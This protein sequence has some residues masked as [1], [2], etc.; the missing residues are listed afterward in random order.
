MTI[1]IKKLE[2]YLKNNKNVLFCGRHGVG[3]TAVITELFNKQ[4]GDRWAYFSASTM[5]PWVDFIGVPKPYK[6]KDGEEVLRLIKP[7]R[8][9]DD[10]VEALFFDE[11]NRSQAKIRNVVMEL[12]QFKS[13]N[14]KKYKNLKVV[15]AAINPPDEGIYDV[16]EIDPAQLDRF[17]IQIDIPYKLDTSYFRSKYNEDAEPFIQWWNSLTLENKHKVSPRRLDEAI[18]VYHFGGDLRDV[19]DKK[20]N[21]TEL[22]KIIGEHNIEKQWDDLISLNSKEQAIFFMN[23]SNVSKFEDKILLNFPEVI[24]MIPEDYIIKML[25][26]DRDINWLKLSIINSDRI[27]D[28]IKKSVVEYIHSKLKNRTKNYTFNECIE[29]IGRFKT[30]K[31]SNELL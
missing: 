21:I 20:T 24:E 1:N 17:T 14:G 2:L 27:S 9:H 10:E 16:E 3:K 7:E 22:R 25:L 8:F 11:Y 26:I 12:T 4:F 28:F 18:E 5:D 23:I 6:R 15:W 29:K 30:N 13:I 19:L 31:K